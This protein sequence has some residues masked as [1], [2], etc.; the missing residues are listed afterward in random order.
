LEASSVGSKKVSLPHEA[1][2]QIP[3][4]QALF[5]DGALRRL[6]CDNSGW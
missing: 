6:V 4:Y 1:V 2:D 5:E 3:F